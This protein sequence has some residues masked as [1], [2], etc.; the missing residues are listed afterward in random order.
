IFCYV[1]AEVSVGSVLVNFLSS[2]GIGQGLSEQEA[3]G[4]VSL[5]WGGALA[6]RLVGTALLAR[7]DAR[8]LLGLFALMV[9]VL[10]GI[11]VTASGGVAK[12]AVVST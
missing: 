9:M 2:P 4:Y 8:Q 1:G 11:T 3:T 5:Y 7:L 10:L 6:G 12:W